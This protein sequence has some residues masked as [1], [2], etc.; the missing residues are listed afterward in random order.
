MGFVYFIQHNGSDV[1]ALRCTTS[2]DPGNVDA[3]IPNDDPPECESFLHH[4]F[5]SK[6]LDKKAKLFRLGTEDLGVATKAAEGFAR[7][8]LP[9]HHAVEQLKTQ[10]S[11]NRLMAPEQR[12]RELCRQIR[13][14]R[15]Q[16]FRIS[17]R[18][19]LLENELKVAIGTSAGIEGLATWKSHVQNTFDRERFKA[20]HPDIFNSY[21]HPKTMRT[22]QLI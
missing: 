16:E 5:E 2:A 22:L 15:E 6:C 14:L 13:E 21:V 7:R 12:H 9:L 3:K 4:Y 11:N 17:K 8:F 20:E 18:R 10:S 1:Y 19:E